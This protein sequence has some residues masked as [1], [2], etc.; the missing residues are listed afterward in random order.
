[1]PATYAELFDEWD[2]RAEDFSRDCYGPSLDER[3]DD[4]RRGA[5]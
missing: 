4:P 3:A 5:A 1:M 2:E